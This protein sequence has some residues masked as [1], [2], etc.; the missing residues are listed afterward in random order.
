VPRPTVDVV[1]PFAGPREDL[2]RLSQTL[3]GLRL[4]EGD[5]VLIVDNTPRPKRGGRRPQDGVG[6]PGR[7]GAAAVPGEGGDS[8]VPIEGGAAAVPIL[9]AAERRTPG[10][11]RNRGAERGGAEWMLFIDADTI[12]PGDL[13]DRYFDPEPGERTAVVGGGVRDEP[14][15]VGGP[16]AARYAFIRAATSQEDTFRF[17]EWGFPKTAN[18][19]VRRAAFD[20]V[21]GFREDI[22]TA[23]DADLVFR[24]RAAGWDVERREQA[25][26]SH[27]GRQTVGSFVHQR[28]LYGAGGAWLERRY[29][30]SFPAR[31]RAGLIVWAVAKCGW[32][33][34]R[35]ARARDRD[36]ALWAV[37]EPLE[38]VVWEFGRSLPNERPMTA[39]VWWRALRGLRGPP[40]AQ[41]I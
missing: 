34:L 39:A 17:G 12:P 3:T 41:R 24:L 6:T 25:A 32:R 37:F 11:A 1:V 22:R 31:R 5:S 9:H 33:L 28:L 20:A 40:G 23:E 16:P 21:G 7:E 26:V 8:A 10:Y 35:A 19:A 36:E 30:G 15:P 27:R 18:A 2:A 4:R 14:V 13:L 29:P 38:A